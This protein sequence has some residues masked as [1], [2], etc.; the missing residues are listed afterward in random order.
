MWIEGK[1]EAVENIAQMLSSLCRQLREEN[2][3]IAD[4]PLDAITQFIAKVYDEGHDTAFTSLY[5]RIMAEFAR[6][7]M[8]ARLA[9]TIELS[10]YHAILVQCFQE[11]QHILEQ[12]S[13]RLQSRNAWY[14]NTERV[15]KWQKTHYSSNKK[16]KIPFS[17]RGVVYSAVTGSYDKINEPQYINPELDYILFTDDPHIQSDV[18]QV[19]LLHN[20]EQLD[21]TRLARKVKLL[22]HQYLEGYDYSIWVDGKL[23]ITGDLQDFTQKYRNRQPILCFNHPAYDCIYNEKDRCA[24]INK[25]S[26]NLMSEQTERYRQEGY[27]EHNGLIESAILVRELKDQRL[28]SLME[29]W[30]QEVLHGS[31]RDQLSFN[32]VCWKHDFVYDST[33]LYI[34]GNKYVKLYNH[35]Q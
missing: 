31:K 35:K 4:M 11:T 32:Y 24:E 12:K 10:L 29:A 6:H 34:Y 5:S 7:G 33:D 28:I 26:P 3:Q 21:N 2:I 20:T 25:D 22:G 1:K 9:D 14:I 8:A 17:G 30:W 18:W 13:F 23:A 19:R 27:P 16:N 15:K